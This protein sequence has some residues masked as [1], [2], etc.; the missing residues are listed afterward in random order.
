MIWLENEKQGWGDRNLTSAIKCSELLL[1]LLLGTQCTKVQLNNMANISAGQGK[2]FVLFLTLGICTG[3]CFALKFR[4]QIFFPA[5]QGGS[6]GAGG[7]P[8]LR[9]QDQLLDT[10]RQH[11]MDLRIS[12]G[13]VWSGRTTRFWVTLLESAQAGIA[14][15]RSRG[16]HRSSQNTHRTPVPT[17]TALAGFDLSFP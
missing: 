17:F 15:R 8:G 12:A 13:R 9:A 14:V 16:E 11:K 3:L 2:P 10:T 5:L 6:W 4:G 1:F 7:D